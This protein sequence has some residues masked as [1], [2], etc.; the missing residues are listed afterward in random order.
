MEQMIL[1]SLVTQQAMQQAAPILVLG[2]LV[3]VAAVLGG[4]A[5]L[6]IAYWDKKRK[7]SVC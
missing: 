1:S 7:Q 3:G 4:T 2:L 6:F 5:L